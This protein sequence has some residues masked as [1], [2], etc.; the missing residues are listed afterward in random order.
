MLT[1]QDLDQLLKYYTVHTTTQ[2]AALASWSE[3]LYC[4]LNELS[5]PRLGV[6]VLVRATNGIERSTTKGRC[7]PEVAASSVPHHLWMWTDLH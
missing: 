6:D 7:T 5:H 2:G 4:H 1:V 3:Q